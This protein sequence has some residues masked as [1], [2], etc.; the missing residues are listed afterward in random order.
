MR[1]SFDS[2]VFPA[3]VSV[4]CAV[5]TRRVVK[6]ISIALIALALGCAAD[7]TGSTGGGSDGPGGGGKADG[8]SAVTLTFA[9]DYS[10]SQSGTLRA[11]GTVRLD[12]DLDR[13]ED[14]RGTQGGIPQWGA[15]AVYW[16]DDGEEQTIGLTEIVGDEIRATDAILTVPEGEKLSMYFYVNNTWGCIAYDSDFG[17][18]YHFEV[19]TRPTAAVLT[20]GVDFAEPQLEGTLRAG[21]SVVVEYD[22]D[23]SSECRSTRGAYPVWDVAVRYTFDGAGPEQEASL[24]RSGTTG[25]EPAPATIRLPAEASEL[26]LVFRN[27]DIYG[28]EVWDPALGESYAFELTR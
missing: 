16:G 6:K 20:F 24:T 12:Y 18:N 14:C 21:G 9:G 4:A 8:D 27:F 7:T 26:S 3:A 19:E 25:R 23:R 2:L 28:C 1:S 13:I 10:E 17:A 15:T 22:L 11:G 5:H